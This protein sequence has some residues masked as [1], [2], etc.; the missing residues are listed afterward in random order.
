VLL[1]DG[2]EALETM[3]R[4][5]WDIR[6][7]WEECEAYLSALLRDVEFDE[8]R[9]VRNH[10]GVSEWLIAQH[11]GSKAL[12]IQEGIYRFLC[13]GATN[14]DAAV[15]EWLSRS[16]DDS[17]VSAIAI[18][19]L[20]ASAAA[21]NDADVRLRSASESLRKIIQSSRSAADV[22]AA[23][24]ALD[25]LGIAA[26]V[27]VDRVI[28]AFYQFAT[29][30]ARDASS[31]LGPASE[32]SLSHI[33]RIADV[34]EAAVVRRA[35][36]LTV[37]SRTR[38]QDLAKDLSQERDDGR[39]LRLSLSAIIAELSVSVEL[40]SRFLGVFRF[41]DSN[42]L[43][44]SA[45]PRPSFLPLP[46][47]GV[48]DA[49]EELG[50]IATSFVSAFEELRTSDIHIL[51][52]SSM[53]RGSPY[54]ER[55][56]TRSFALCDQRSDPQKVLE[57]AFDRRLADEAEN[58]H[59]RELLFYKNEP[60]ALPHVRTAQWLGVHHGLLALLGWTFDATS[61]RYLAA[62]GEERA[63]LIWWSDGQ[64]GVNTRDSGDRSAIGWMI[65]GSLKA[66]G[67]I[68]TVVGAVEARCELHTMGS[69]RSAIGRA[70]A[71][72]RL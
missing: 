56:I 25:K 65:L 36:S 11:L 62:D 15:V 66:L 6:A 48:G 3:T 27:N 41:F 54:G 2:L 33:A 23:L 64:M 72:V 51:A 16:I 58:S 63:R 70:S 39:A 24:V 1:I 37:P 42:L 26:P 47:E 22:E 18:N 5:T 61:L 57:R 14:A 67:D 44:I 32:A 30:A 8:L 9:L 21:G 4:T 43:G 68:V 40:R 28:P 34:D 29:P 60:I 71:N 19:V 69:G 50:P 59:A 13:S 35:M 52:E 31:A 53:G 38:R 55:L 7:I 17:E 20:V 12:L 49:A 46:S 45:Q 10:G